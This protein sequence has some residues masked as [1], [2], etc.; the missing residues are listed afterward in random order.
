MGEARAR[1]ARKPTFAS[2]PRN[3]FVK[4]NSDDGLAI[5]KNIFVTHYNARV[6]M[7]RPFFRLFYTCLSVV[8]RK[9]TNGFRTIKVDSRYC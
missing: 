8:C 3:L 7:M 9:L 6:S 1:N 2:C 4:E 5:R